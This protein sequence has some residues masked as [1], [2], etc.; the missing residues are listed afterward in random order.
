M[1][2]KYVQTSTSS[3]ILTNLLESRTKLVAAQDW[4]TRWLTVCLI[5]RW[6]GRWCVSVDWQVTRSLMCI[7]WLT[8]D[9]VADVYLEGLDQFR[10]WFQSSL[11]T[12]VACR[13]IAPFKYKA[14][15]AVHW[16][17]AFLRFLTF[18]RKL[19]FPGCCLVNALV[20]ILQAISGSWFCF[21]PISYRKLVVHQFVFDRYLTGSW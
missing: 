8:G 12:S 21:W 18:L 17:L 2:T 11:L 13:G 3:L 16:L 15:L 20:D 14:K 6:Q 10:G 7:C 19:L 5:G 1:T 4:L 9:Q